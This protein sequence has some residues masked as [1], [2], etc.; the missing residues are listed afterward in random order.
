MEK[1]DVYDMILSLVL[2]ICA[3]VFI[4]L[5]FSSVFLGFGVCAFIV[6]L[7]AYGIPNDSIR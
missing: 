4:G 7:K 6:W 3:S 2:I 1:Y 5:A